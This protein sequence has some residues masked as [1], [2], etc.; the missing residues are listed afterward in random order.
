MFG[1]MKPL[2]DAAQRLV[3]DQIKDRMEETQH[4]IVML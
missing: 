3:T 1:E 4:E 2:L